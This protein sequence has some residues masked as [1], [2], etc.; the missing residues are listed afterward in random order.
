MNVHRAMY[1]IFG[2]CSKLLT[3]IEFHLAYILG[4]H[5]HIKGSRRSLFGHLLSGDVSD[6]YATSRMN[7][8][9]NPLTP[10]FFRLGYLTIDIKEGLL[11]V[12]IPGT[13][14]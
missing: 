14:K 13:N 4:T 5:P 12:L 7:D 9:I 8:L 6:N 10:E 1:R 2:G 3:N 11:L